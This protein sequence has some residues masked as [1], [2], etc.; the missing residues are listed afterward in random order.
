M[1]LVSDQKSHFINTSIELLV[2]DVNT[3]QI[4]HLISLRKWLCKINQENV[5]VEMDQVNKC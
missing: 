1:H 5:E 4:Y 3:S 2:Q